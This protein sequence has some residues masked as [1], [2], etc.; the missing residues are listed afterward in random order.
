MS[1]EQS[2]HNFLG[3]Q[4]SSCDCE[5]ALAYLRMEAVVAL[6]VAA[7]E[8]ASQSNVSLGRDLWMLQWIKASNHQPSLSPVTT[9]FFRFVPLKIITAAAMQW[10]KRPLSSTP[11]LSST[12]QLVQA[13]AALVLHWK[14]T[15]ASVR[16]Q[17]RPNR[18]QCLYFPDFIV[19]LCLCVR[20]IH[21]W[22]SLYDV[23]CI[24]MS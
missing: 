11:L 19:F 2:W 13:A 4:A 9:Y 6:L 20:R 3:C 5:H 18:K 16:K 24:E 14:Y 7:V 17:D 15:C 23:C 21:D 22:L 8:Y 10:I 1:R 12:V